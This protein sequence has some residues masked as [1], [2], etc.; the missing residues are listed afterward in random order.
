M[1]SVTES[2]HVTWDPVEYELRADERH[3]NPYTDVAVTATFEHESGDTHEI[4]G[5]WDGGDA[6]KVRFAPTKSGE[7]TWTSESDVGDEGLSASGR[8]EA[9]DYRG[10][11]PLKA[12][13]F[14][15]VD[16]DGRHIV[17][18]DGTPFF[19]LGDTVWSAPA[20]ATLEEWEDYLVRRRAQGFT[21]AQM[22][23][24]PQWDTSEPIRR[25]PFRGEWDLDAPNPEYFRALDELVAAGHER[26]VVSA[27][28]VLWF[29][30]VAGDRD[31]SLTNTFSPAQARRYGRYLAA[32]Y[33]PYGAAWFVS[34][35]ADLPEESIDVYEAAGEAI[36]V[37]TSHALLSTHMHPRRETPERFDDAEWFDFHSYQS[38]HYHGEGRRRAFENAAA[39]RDRSPPR[40][41]LNSE[42]CYEGYGFLDLDDSELD[43]RDVPVSRE[44]VRRAAWW[45]VLAGANAG[46][47]YGASGT[48][49][50]FHPG[51]RVLR[52]HL[53][54]PRPWE[55]AAEFPGAD[56]YARLKEF[57]TGYRFGA[58][59]PRQDLLVD[60]DAAVRAAELDGDAVVY[61]PEGG[62]VT[63]EPDVLGPEAS[64]RWF[65]PA[66]GREVPAQHEHTAEGARIAGAPWRGDAVLICPATA[67][68]KR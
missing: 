41:V 27:F 65:D 39:H 37:A 22:N 30:F 54:M 36:D 47:T 48:W 15:R 66:T 19:W 52:D 60:E 38:G 8:F 42:P 58:L 59:S 33:G 61:A 12:H 6:W 2:H 16:D 34:G 23:S 44:D 10:G 67:D 4:P 50:W 68:P 25:Y 14:L 53:P 49:H 17:H 57:L 20:K 11:N 51:E 1:N 28:I 18:E 31:R 29:N 63:V 64:P 35:D 55:E 7:W 43:P 46:I 5:F 40:P 9:A 32:R 62:A 56:D 45:S 26:G 24:L 21:V 3:E 13:G